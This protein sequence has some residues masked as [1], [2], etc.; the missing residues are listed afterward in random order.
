MS[1]PALWWVSSF[2]PSLIAG[3]LA[4]GGVG[5]LTSHFT[6][7]LKRGDVKELGELLD[8]GQAGIVFVGVV[9]PD[10]SMDHL[11]T[12]ALTTMTKQ[13]DANAEELKKAMRRGGH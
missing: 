3:A 5:L 12:H 8:E 9:D 6:K 13:V 11:L 1:P 2:P 7:G 10:Q 4:G